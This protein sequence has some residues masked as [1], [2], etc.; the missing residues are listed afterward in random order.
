MKFRVLIVDDS[1]AVRGFHGSILRDAGFEIEEAANGYEALEKYFKNKFDLLLVDVNMPK[2]HGYELIRQI[3]RHGLYGFVPAIIISTESGENDY[4]EAFRAGANLYL[5]KPVDPVC[6][7]LSARML[8]GINTGGNRLCTIR[9][10]RKKFLS[11]LLHDKDGDIYEVSLQTADSGAMEVDILDVFCKLREIGEVVHIAADTREL[12]SLQD[13]DPSIPYVSLTFIVVTGKN[14]QEIENVV[15]GTAGPESSMRVLVSTVSL[16]EV[17]DIVEGRSNSETISVSEDKVNEVL[18]L[19][20]SQQ[21]VFYKIV[22]TPEEQRSRG[23][24]V[25]NLLQKAAE[26]MGWIAKGESLI[27]AYEKNKGK[28]PE[29]FSALISWIVDDKGK[30]AKKEQVNISK[31]AAVE[32]DEKVAAK[33]SRGDGGSE[34]ETTKTLKVEQS[35]VDE[36]M[37]LVGELIVANNGLSYMIRKVEIK[38]G[39]SEITRELKERQVLLNRIGKDLQ[40]IVMGLRLLPVRYIFDR[41]PRM[42][43]QISRKLNKKVRLVTE[44]EET[45]IDKN[46]VTALYDPMLHII[47][48]AIDHGIEEPEA[49]LKNGKPEEGTLV[50]SAQRVGDKV[51]VE[52]RD[53]GRG[54]DPDVVRAKAVEKGFVSIEEAAAMKDD[55]ALEL[56]FLPGFSTSEGVTELSG[57]GVGMDVIRD[58]VKKLG[59]NVRVVSRVGKGTSVF[60]ELPV[61]MVTSRVLL[62]T[63]QGRRYAFPLESVREMVKIKAV[64]VRRMKGKEIVVLRQEVMPL[65][66]LQEFMGLQD[67]MQKEHEFEEIPLVVLNSGMAVMV[68]EFV[69]E[70]EIIVRPLSEEFSSATCFLGAAILGDGNIVLVL[71]PEELAGGV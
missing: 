50:M 10:E 23:E 25:I 8:T 69:G 71:N 7:Q 28:W 14:A 11:E 12:P 20:I 47:R 45:Q 39:L 60:M 17:G 4:L 56:L 6:L 62:I 30:T 49:R 5:E 36:L 24:M 13:F 40:D 34:S 3:R 55:E 21:E 65:L 42:I 54:I 37:N 48:N 68:D 46:I 26:S 16:D 53:D 19:I 59:G 67:D 61:T 63:V 32:R 18:D 31:P 41:F 64:D 58:T 38:Y 15:R 2:M 57:R 29:R 22:Q 43:R 33:T 9:E 70:Q 1:A 27:D 35:K 66:R 51:M 44:G 52:V